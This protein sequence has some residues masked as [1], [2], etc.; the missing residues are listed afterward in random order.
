MPKVAI[1]IF[2]FLLL[3]SSLLTSSHAYL[4][5]DLNGIENVQNLPNFDSGIVQIDSDFFVEN[6]YKRYLVFGTNCK[7]TIS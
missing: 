2:M 3:P 5:A 7:M 1:F 4:P 6:N